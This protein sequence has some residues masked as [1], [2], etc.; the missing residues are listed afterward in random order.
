MMLMSLS[1]PLREILTVYFGR[2]LIY[3]I[4]ST[5]YIN[6]VLH[7]TCE[8]DATSPNPNDDWDGGL[9]FTAKSTRKILCHFC[10]LY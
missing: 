3:L 6:E 7:E 5:D 8:D 4:F 10:S 2:I 1:F 9:T